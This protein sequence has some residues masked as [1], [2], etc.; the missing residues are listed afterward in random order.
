MALCLF[1]H[2]TALTLFCTHIFFSHPQALS[3]GLA[4]GAPGAVYIGI[5]LYGAGLGDVLR[6]HLWR[7]VG[8]A[9]SG[10]GWSHCGGGNRR[11]RA[12]RNCGVAATAACE[13]NI[14]ERK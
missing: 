5:K 3:G 6:T 13:A 11:H 2:C 7:D 14:D 8:A 9:V 10:A 4:A 1:F 12:F